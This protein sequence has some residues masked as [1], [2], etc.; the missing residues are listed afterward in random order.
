M[1]MRTKWD[2]KGRVINDSGHLMLAITNLKSDHSII[3]MTMIN[4]IIDCE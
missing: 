1:R 4:V 2:V 3:E